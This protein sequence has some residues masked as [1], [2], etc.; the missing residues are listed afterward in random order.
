[1]VVWQGGNDVPRKLAGLA[2]DGM[3][4]SALL[5]AAVKSEKR[6]RNKNKRRLFFEQWICIVPVEH[7]FFNW[8][9]LCSLPCKMTSVVL[10]KG[11]RRREGSVVAPYLSVGSVCS[12]LSIGSVCSVLS[13]MRSTAN[14]HSQQITREGVKMQINSRALLHNPARKKAN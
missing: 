4:Q 8:V 9:H 11:Q 3:N 6:R 7:F 12:V 2:V 13:V 1:M 14:L 5:R 10:S